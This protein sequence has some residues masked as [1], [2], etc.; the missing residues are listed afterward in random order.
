MDYT[1]PTLQE[2]LEWVSV[3]AVLAILMGGFYLVAKAFL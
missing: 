3:L 1:E 2:I